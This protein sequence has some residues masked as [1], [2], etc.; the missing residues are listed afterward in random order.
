M[1]HVGISFRWARITK[2]YAKLRYQVD[3]GYD[4]IHD[5]V[6]MRLSAIKPP[7]NLLRFTRSRSPGAESMFYAFEWMRRVYQ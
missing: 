5:I 6:F 3:E 4:T 1:S 7:G 2:V